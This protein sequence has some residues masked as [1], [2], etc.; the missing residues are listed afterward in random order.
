MIFPSFDAF[1]E[2]AR[3]GYTVIP[4]A[5]R[6]PFDTET[7]VTAYA[8]IFQPPFGF[9]LESVVGAEKWARYTFLGSAPREVIRLHDGKLSRWLPETSSWS[10]IA[11]QDNPLDY[12]E[13]RLLAERAAPV[14]GIPRFFGGVVGYLGY[15][16]I[17]YIEQLPSPPSDDLR[18]PE[19]VL[20]FTD[21]VLAIDNVFGHAMAIACAHLRGDEKDAELRKHYDRALHDVAQIIERLHSAP[22][23]QPLRMHEDEPAPSFDSSFA[24]A[25]FEAAVERIRAYIAAGDAFQVVLSQRLSTALTAAPFELY[26]ALR[27]VNPS[28]YLYLL[29]LDGMALVGSSPEVLVRVEAGRVIV[30]PIAGTRPRGASDEDDARLSADLL[31][32]AKERAEHLM[33][34]DLGRN[35]VGRVTRYGTVRVSEFMAI[36]R[37]SH[38]LHMVSQVEGELEPDTSVIAVLRACFPAG[39]VSGAP[40]IRAMEIIDELEPVRRGPYGGAVGYFT[41]GGSEMDT[42]IAIRT[43]IAVG[44]RAYVQAGAGVVADSVPAREYQ[45]TLAK[46]GALL[47]V[48]GAFK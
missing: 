6:F 5:Q 17:R 23:V 20:L 18:L 25:D 32:D 2:F 42:A 9:L 12:L 31:A 36:E 35:D 34:I 7:A 39:T 45:E 19:A 46:E 40:K 38:V 47:K 29:E 48:I 3:A 37:Y 43:L 11:I 16:V 4:I 22:G 44:D 28:P 15:D 27:S 1:R 26:R 13:A 30:R 33:L 14:P 24:R 10:D 21:V 8:K 41:Y